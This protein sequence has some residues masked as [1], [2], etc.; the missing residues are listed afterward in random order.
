MTNDKIRSLVDCG[1]IMVMTGYGITMIACS[2][3]SNVVFFIGASIWGIGLTT[4][5]IALISMIKTKLKKK[6]KE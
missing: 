6:K 2:F 1:A 3:E 4:V 5:I